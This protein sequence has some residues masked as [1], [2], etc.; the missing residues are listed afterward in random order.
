MKTWKDYLSHAEFLLK[1]GYIKESI[2]VSE[3]A[4]KIEK[5][6]KEKNKTKEKK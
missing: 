3:L 5:K 4:E 6:E 2:S 1:N